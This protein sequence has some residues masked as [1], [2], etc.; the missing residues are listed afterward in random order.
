MSKQAQGRQGASTAAMLAVPMV[1]AVAAGWLVVS[2]PPADRAGAPPEPAATMRA[3]PDFVLPPLHSGAEGLRQADL[4]GAVSVVNFWA[5]WC[6][7]CREEMPLL[8]DLAGR[9]PVHG[10]NVRDDPAAAARFLAETGDPFRRVGR[11]ADGAVSAGWGV[12]GLPATFIVDAG[13]AVAYRLTGPL[14]RRILDR[15]ILPVIAR[16]SGNAAGQ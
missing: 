3:V 14:D 10:V 16:L 2:T 8:E 11:D 7:P 6:G 1:V 13:G 4:L 12:Y 15:D 9:V 5:T